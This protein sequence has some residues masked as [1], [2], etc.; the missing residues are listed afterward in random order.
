M[1]PFDRI[2]GL[3]ALVAILAFNVWYT[4]HVNAESQARQC[5]D[6]AA[7]LAL[8]AEIPPDSPARQSRFE[9]YERKWA[10]KCVH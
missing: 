1:K 8:Y 10:E 5:E 7:E 2:F 3:A 4:H 9:L 6:Y